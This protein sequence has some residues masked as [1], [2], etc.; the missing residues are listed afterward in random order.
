[1]QLNH[2]Y[3]L[4]QE[5]NSFNPELLTSVER[6]QLSNLIFEA[7]KHQTNS[8]AVTEINHFKK[9]YSLYIEQPYKVGTALKILKYDGAKRKSKKQHSEL[10]EIMLRFVNKSWE[11]NYDYDD[12]SMT[13]TLDGKRLDRLSLEPSELYQRGSSLKNKVSLINSLPIGNWIL[14]ELVFQTCGKLL[15]LIFKSLSLRMF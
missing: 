14:A 9:F 3:L 13:L 11:G 12:V 15:M 5:F 2:I 6:E 4:R 10:V 7:Q 8:G 1:M